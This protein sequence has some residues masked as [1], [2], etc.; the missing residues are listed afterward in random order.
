M[1]LPVPVAPG[2]AGV[3]LVDV[4]AGQI[5]VA[6][7]E[8]AAVV[9][10]GSHDRGAGRISSGQEERHGVPV[11]L[12]GADFSGRDARGVGKQLEGFQVL[13]GHEAGDVAASDGA[14]LGL[15]GQRVDGTGQAG[16]A[17]DPFRQVHAVVDLLAVPVPLVTAVKVLPVLVQPE[18]GLGPEFGQELPRQSSQRVL[19]DHGVN[20][21]PVTAQVAADIYRSLPEADRTA[22]ATAV[23]TQAGVLWLGNHDHPDDEAAVHP[24]YADHLAATLAERGHMHPEANEPVEATLARRGQVNQTSYSPESKRPRPTRQTSAAASQHVGPAM[25]LQQPE[26]FQRPS[27]PVPGR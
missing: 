17:E 14:F 3:V 1:V 20:A 27:G 15:V 9:R 22:I 26:P 23:A 4:S 7:D 18:A 11:L 8:R 16:R 2:P 25:P 21:D 19:L 24:A 5:L 10:E 6:V 13:L 12:G